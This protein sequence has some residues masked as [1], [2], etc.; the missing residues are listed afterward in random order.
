MTL[1][2]SKSLLENAIKTLQIETGNCSIPTKNEI[3]AMLVER[4]ANE[5]CA[6]IRR[7]MLED[8]PGFNNF[9]FIRS[10]E[11]VVEH[12]DEIAPSVM[13]VVKARLREAGWRKVEFGEHNCG[14]TKIRIKL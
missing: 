8:L 5:V 14:I 1:G 7:K 2:I 10:Y 4:Q 3:H 12:K 11:I 9:H 13:K 6:G